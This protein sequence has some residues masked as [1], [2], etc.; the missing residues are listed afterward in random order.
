MSLFN[1]EQRDYMRYLASL[2]REAKCDCGWA[3]R[4][5]CR[6]VV[7]YGYPERGGV[8]IVEEKEKG[9]E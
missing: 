6:S 5:Q 8:P 9:N 1:S 2:P 7:C 4:G 3:L